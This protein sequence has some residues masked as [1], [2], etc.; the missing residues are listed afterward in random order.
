LVVFT[1]CCF[2]SHRMR[3]GG[4]RFRGCTSP[5]LSLI[6]STGVYSTLYRIL[7]FISLSWFYFLFLFQIRRL[8]DY[9]ILGLVALHTAP[10]KFTSIFLLVLNMQ[11]FLI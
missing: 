4:R 2:L 10:N 5:V 9:K 8:T 7:L 3:G 1:Y 11:A 6:S